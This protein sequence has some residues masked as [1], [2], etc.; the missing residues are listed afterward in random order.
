RH[1]IFEPSARRGDAATGSEHR[2]EVRAT[3]LIDR[4]RVALDCLARSA[5]PRRT[6][7]MA[8]CVVKAMFRGSDLCMHKRC[9]ERVVL[10]CEFQGQRIQTVEGVQMAEKWR[11]KTLAT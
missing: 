10:A 1:Q 8:S 11:C 9:A 7:E 6:C 3:R 5:R 2:I 4:Q